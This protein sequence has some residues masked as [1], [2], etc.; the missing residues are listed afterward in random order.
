VAEPVF[1][2]LCSRCGSCMRACPE[3]IIVP[4]WGIGGPGSMLTPR[5]D[6]SRRY[7]NE[8]CRVCT[9][10]CPT[11][12]IRRLSLEDKRALSIGMAQ[13]DRTH[14]LA[15]KDSQYCMVCYEFCSYQA[16]RIVEHNGVNCPEV[17]EAQCRGCGACQ[18]HCPAELPRAI[19]VRARGQASTPSKID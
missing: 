1:W 2:G 10:V 4:D 5:L 3:S 7:C 14:C 16:V 9:G 17:N 15:W 8:W 18:S 11:G 19:V 6:F 13:V 12:A